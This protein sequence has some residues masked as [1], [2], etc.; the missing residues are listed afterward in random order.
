[1]SVYSKEDP[2]YFT[3]AIDSMLSQ[4]VKPFEIVIVCDGTLTP[5]LDGVIAKYVHTY[6]ELFKV[7]RLSKNGGLANA[8]NQ[9]LEYCHCEYIFRMDTDD[10][11]MPNR[12]ETQ[13]NAMLLH[14]ADICSA[15]IEEFVDNPNVTYAKKVVP[16]TNED[17]RAYSKKRNPFNHPCVAYRKSK[18]LAVGKYEQYPLFEDYHL[19]IKMLNANCIGYNCPDT[20][21]KMRVGAGMYSRRG[22]WQ[23]FKYALKLER[24]KLNLG[25]YTLGDYIQCVAVK[26]VFSLTPTKLRAILYQKLLRR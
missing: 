4:T 26:L 21:L 24:Y 15:T 12:V 1:M 11:S 3:C 22:G 6:G 8:L 20:L 17:I 18:V 5:P 14:H 7:V 25:Y 13:L 2:N 23:Y 16:T 19:W 10:I 9:G